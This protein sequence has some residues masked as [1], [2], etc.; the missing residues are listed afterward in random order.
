M[1]GKQSFSMRVKEEAAGQ[2]SSR[3]HCQ[4]AELA[5]ILSL[6]ETE[7]REDELKIHLENVYTA[8]KCFTLL[9]KTFNI[10]AAITMRSG[11]GAAKHHQYILR[12]QR[13]SKVR[14]LLFAIKHPVTEGRDPEEPV[15]DLILQK[16][17]C[18]R[19]FVRGCFL[20]AGSVTDPAK[21]YHLEIV[22]PT[23][24]KAKQLCTCM[25]SFW[26]GEDG[27]EA[28]TIVRTKSGGRKSFVVYIKEGNQISDLLNIC[29]TYR[30]LMEMENIRVEKEI[31]NSVNRKLNCEMANMV[32]TITAAQEQKNDI[33]YIDERIGL[34]NLPSDLEQLARIRLEDTEMSLKELGERLTPP[35]G[36]SGVNHRLRKIKKIAD[37]LRDGK[38]YP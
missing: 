21:S 23:E 22:C 3:R 16:N 2:I 12:V 33:L 9:K 37:D 28:K 29:E 6:S 18:R 14:E 36:K 4:N 24:E 35:I 17:C 20:A 31:A 32:K 7:I 30:C 27:M 1:S 38:T 10:D 19:A 11:K 25:N 34:E 5:A 15:N 13:A 26:Q 8:K